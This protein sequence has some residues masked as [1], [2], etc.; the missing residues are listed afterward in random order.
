MEKEYRLAID[1][2]GKS[3]SVA[4]FKR[5]DL[6]ITETLNLNNQHSVN[7]MPTIDRLKDTIE[8]EMDVL[9]A[10]FVTIGPGSF[11]GIRIGI[12]TA[13]TIGYTLQIPVYGV[14]SLEALAYPYLFA[15][16]HITIPAFDARGGRVFASVYQGDARLSHDQQFLNDELPE[17]LLSKN[18]KDE[19]ILLIGDG[20]ETVETLLRKFDF[21][22]IKRIEPQAGENNISAASIAML[23]KRQMQLLAMVP[24]KFEPVMPNYCAITQAERNLQSKGS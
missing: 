2:S 16:D 6:L 11:T 15:H 4:F 3:L 8:I 19:T 1:T 5:D 7:L 13:N 23:G 20:A 18:L 9:E 10:V 14:S 24:P 12:A 22:H 21:Q 17:F